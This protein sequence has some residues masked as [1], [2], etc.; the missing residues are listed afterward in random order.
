MDEEHVGTEQQ[1]VGAIDIGGTKVALGLVAH[2]GRVLARRSIP[3]RDLAN[4]TI[5][6][7]AIAS[8]LTECIQE[9]GIAPEGIGIGCTGPV[10]PITGEIGK[11]ANLPGWHGC[12]IVEEITSRIGMRTVMENDAD[13]AALAEATWGSGRGVER[14]L[15]ITLSTGIGAGFLLGSNV[16]RGAGGSHPEMG[17]HA[18]DPAGPP[19]YCGAR[20][21]WESLASGN[22]LRDWFLE[23]DRE[24]RFS[25]D[26]L[27]AR[28]IFE[29]YAAGDRVAEQAVERLSY[30]VGLGIAN[31]TTILVPDVI[32]IGGGLTRGSALFLD[33]AV[34][35]FRNR[36]GEVPAERT[37][38]RT[39]V[40]EENLDLAGAAA[41]WLH[42]L[43]PGDPI[44]VT[45]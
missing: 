5:G 33:R 43:Q 30:Y 11:V 28:T 22:A 37:L 35:I 42:S 26:T 27:D 14:F 40:L 18:I 10:D 4:A 19:C 21:C 12:R 16:Y 44:E 8:S 41:V 45:R 23:N 29:L 9:S 7:E 31:L 25:F 15:Y 6:V 13:A 2:D 32:A 34:R 20:G 36:C 38:V 24:E 1:L 17:H 39:A 3:T